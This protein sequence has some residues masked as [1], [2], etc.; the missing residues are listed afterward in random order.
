[1]PQSA[2]RLKTL[3]EG[4]H[5]FGAPEGFRA[6]L[7]E[8]E[9]V[10]TPPGDGDHEKC[11]SR[12][13]RQLIKRSGREMDVS[14]TK[15]LRL[16]GGGTTPD[17]HVIPDATFAPVEL[18]V[19][20]GA[21]PWMPSAGVCLVLDVTPSKRRADRMTARRRCY[22]RAG[23][24]LH[25]SIARDAAQV[26]LFSA[27]GENDYVEHWTRPFGREIPLPGPFAF[28]LDTSDLL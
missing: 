24:P 5:S 9:I 26:T 17:D 14:V 3:L 4:F 8:G 15:G 21:E 28:D 27:P 1:M 25:L 11:L 12:V 6:E 18:D 7:I 19:F 22:A 10:V 2:D 20:S 13:A 16:T 23:I